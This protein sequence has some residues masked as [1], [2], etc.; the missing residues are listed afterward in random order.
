MMEG[1]GQEAASLAGHL[2]LGNL[3][4][5]YDSNRV[6]IEGPTG[7]AFSEDVQA[8]FRAYGWQVIHLGACRGPGRTACRVRAGA[9][10]A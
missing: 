1:L 7:L 3:C 4:W 10:V 6:T 9:P 5:I 2:R 8:R